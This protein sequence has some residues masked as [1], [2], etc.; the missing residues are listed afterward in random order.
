MAKQQTK[1]KQR[2]ADHGEVFTA[3][4][5]VDAM[6]GLVE[7]ETGRIDSRFLEPACGD[8]NF[9]AEIL[10]R[11]L[12]VVKS[13]YGGNAADYE[14]YAVIAAASIYGIDI[15]RDNVDECRARLFGIWD[16]EYTLNCKKQANDEVRAAVQYI[17]SKN[18]VQGDALLPEHELDRIVLPEWSA[19]NGCLIKRRNY[20]LRQMVNGGED[21]Q[22]LDML[23]N[24]GEYEIDPVTHKQILKPGAGEFP[25]THYR[26]L[27]EHG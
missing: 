2:V 6:L 18:I 22:Q 27:P 26:R 24:S 16:E 4:R 20:I 1:S 14:R 17:F 7:Q 12:A 19:V 9:L 11:K 3:K 25:P 10:R 15:L 13:R 23:G 21:D 5:E 8:G